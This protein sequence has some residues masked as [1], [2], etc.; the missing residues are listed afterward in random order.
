VS[1]PLGK[2]GAPLLTH[3]LTEGS[4]LKEKIADFVE[5]PG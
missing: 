2:I 1:D 5:T 3:A 4:K